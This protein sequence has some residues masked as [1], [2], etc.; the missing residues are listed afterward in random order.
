MICNDRDTFSPTWTRF[1]FNDRTLTADRRKESSWPAAHAFVSY[2]R[3]RIVRIH[4]CHSTFHFTSVVPSLFDWLDVTSPRE[5]IT[6]PRSDLSTSIGPCARELFLRSRLSY[7]WVRF[8]VRRAVC[9]PDRSLLEIKRSIEFPTNREIK[10]ASRTDRRQSLSIDRFAG[11][12]CM[13]RGFRASARLG[14]I[15]DSTNL[16]DRP[17][18]YGGCNAR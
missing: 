18:E 5:E 12:L 15:E 8:A 7:L 9:W 13:P 16:F 10:F 11:S 14:K 6:R 4:E 3:Y 2:E 17:N 1:A